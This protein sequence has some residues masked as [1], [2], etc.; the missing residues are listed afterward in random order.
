MIDDEVVSTPLEH[1]G[2]PCPSCGRLLEVISGNGVPVPGTITLCAYCFVFL[3][4]TDAGRQRV[5]TDA[6][7]LELPPDDRA[8]LTRVREWFKGRL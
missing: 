5:M 1:G 8:H 7:W 2:E 6:E 4:L 3:V